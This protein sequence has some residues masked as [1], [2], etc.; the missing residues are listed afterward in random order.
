MAE[1]DRHRVRRAG[2]RGLRHPAGEHDRRGDR[3]GDPQ[4]GPDG[5]GDPHG[6]SLTRAARG[7]RRL[8]HRLRR[9]RLL[10]Q[11]AGGHR[12]GRPVLRR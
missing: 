6:A 11:R 7:D 1:R 10:S 8:R 3:G 5:R 12:Q 4:R 9:A 2:H